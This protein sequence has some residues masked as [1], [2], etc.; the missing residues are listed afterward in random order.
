MSNNYTSLLILLCAMAALPC[1]GQEQ[2]VANPLTPTEADAIVR[3]QM[4]E[5]EQQRQAKVSALESATVIESFEA[6]LGDR[7]VIFNRVVPGSGQVALTAR[8]TAASTAKAS[9]ALSEAEIT[10]LHQPADAKES[11]STFLSA[12][13]FEGPSP[14]SELRWQYE[15]KEYVAYANVDFRY[16]QGLAEFVTDSAHYSVF[17]SAGAGTRTDSGPWVP[18]AE[19][20]SGE[21]IEYL[22]LEDQMSGD[23]SAYGLIDTMLSYYAQHEPEMIVAYQRA[24]AIREAQARYDA[25][26]PPQP[27]DTIINFSPSPESK[28]LQNR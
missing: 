5:K 20:F 23:D 14:V 16:F 19:S 17:L 21:G 6:D 3:Q 10:Q 12:T 8:T 7:K 26:N 24:E 4:A 9:P 1:T 18:G 28:S 2:T 15:G 25:A 11:F 22:V 13:V 27:Q